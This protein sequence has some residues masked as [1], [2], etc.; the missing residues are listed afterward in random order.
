MALKEAYPLRLLCRA[1]GVPRST[2]YYRP[3]GPNP[4][5]A[6][7]RGRLRELAGAWPRY[8]YR[9]LAALL[10]GEGFGVG[11]KRVRSEG[12]LLTRKPLK[13]RTTLPEELLPEGCPTFCWGLR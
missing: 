2:L 11:E 7:L 12:L 9:R 10:R 5:E 3:K 6:L 8:G 1:L 13:P 4:E